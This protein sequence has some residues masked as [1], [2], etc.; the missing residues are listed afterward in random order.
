MTELLKDMFE[1]WLERIRSP[2]FGSIALS[3]LLINWQAVFFLLFAKVPVSTRLDYF[4]ENT[5]VWTLAW[6]PLVFGLGLALFSPWLKFAGA[7]VA[8]KPLSLLNQLQNDQ[9]RAHRIREYE[10]MAEEEDAKALYE[11]AAEQ[12]KID[13]AERLEEAKNV[14]DG[15]VKEELLR[16]RESNKNEPSSNG[17]TKPKLSVDDLT[18]VEVE[19]LR[20]SAA[21]NAGM[22]IMDFVENENYISNVRSLIS[23][24]SYKRLGVDTGSALKNLVAINLVSSK[25]YPSSENPK[26]KSV[27]HY[28]LT[29]EGYSLSDS[30]FE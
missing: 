27:D 9:A 12:R 22:N 25:M 1:S 7:W 13:A 5:S 10:K 20:T 28:S 3:F 19:I 24:F 15:A 17:P 8:T 16:E 29:A 21:A 18:G 30:I 14:G 4:D 6:L 2:F 23:N 26:G 11:A